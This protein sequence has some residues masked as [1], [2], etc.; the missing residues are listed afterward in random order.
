[1]SKD[2]SYRKEEQEDIQVVKDENRGRRLK[3]PEIWEL[4]KI[5]FK[6]FFQGDSFMHGAAFA[7]Y[8]IFALVPI[9]Y[10]AVTSFG[11]IMG[12][13]QVIAIVGDLMESNMGISDVSFFTDLMYKW[14]IGK[15]GTPF[16]QIVGIIFLIFISTA[17]FNSLSKSLNTFFGI[18]PI[19]HYNVVLEELVKRLL[20]FGLMAVFGAIV[21]IMY[22]AQSILIGV[23]SRVLSDGSL[24]QE[25]LFSI[26]EHFSIIAINFLVFTLVFKYLHDG[27]VKWKLAMAGAFFTS[28][29]LY[30]GQL[31]VNYYLANFF[32]AA[33]SGVAG[34]L[35]AVLT[36]IFYISQII[37]LGA[38]YTSVY[39]RMVGMPIKAK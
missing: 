2:K 24:F 3:W 29:L 23:G 13:D 38:K 33:N 19:Q 34:I 25:I 16:L 35:L 27:I 4:T 22:F 15:G 26:L 10:L 8:T 1:M 28:V 9:I 14:E 11:L 20:S 12:Q 30:L 7:Y 39:A 6:E 32:F 21:I 31:A 18:V 37:F 5:S 36:W 17:M